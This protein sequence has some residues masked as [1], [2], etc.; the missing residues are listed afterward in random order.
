MSHGNR[1]ECCK[2]YVTD[3][4]Q[5]LLLLQY[6]EN[7]NDPYGSRWSLGEFRDRQTNISVFARIN[8]EYVDAEHF[9]DFALKTATILF[10]TSKLGGR[11]RLCIARFFSLVPEAASLFFAA[12]LVLPII[13]ISVGKTRCPSSA[14]WFVCLSFVH[15]QASRTWRSAR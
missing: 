7:N 13:M 9:F 5:V 14:R 6:G 3:G 10:Q 12:S 4:Q 8:E 1:E 2:L 15:L 11:A